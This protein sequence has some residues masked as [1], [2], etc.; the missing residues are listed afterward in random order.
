MMPGRRLSHVENRLA[1]F[2]DNLPAQFPRPFLRQIRIEGGP[3]L[4]GIRALAIPFPYPLTV[5]CGRNG[6]GKSTILGL[7][8]VSAKAPQGWSVFWGNTR[9][10]T[11]PNV[12]LEYSFNDFFHRRR[13][14]PSLD[15]LIL[16][17]VSFIQGNDVEIRETP[18]NRRWIRVNE[19]GRLPQRERK[20][21][22]EIDFIPMARILPAS[23]LGVVRAAFDTEDNAVIEPLNAASI[24]ALSFIMGR[25]YTAAETKF[26]RGLGLA[27]CH[28]GSDYS[29]FDMGSGENSVISLLSRLQMIP[30]G[31]LV[32][33]EEIELGL[34]AEA[35]VRLVEELLNICD[36]RR[37][38]IICTTHSEVVLDAVPRRARVLIRKNGD[39][40]EALVDV[41]TRFAVHEMTGQAQPELLAYTEDRLAAAIV[42]EAIPGAQWPRVKILDVGSNAT[43]ARQ[44]VAHL[45]MAPNIKSVAIFD[46]DCTEA[47]VLQWIRE[48]RAERDLQPDWLILPADGLAPEPW[49]IRE[50]A[51]ADYLSEFCRALDCTQAIGLGHIQ[52]MAAQRDHHDSGYTL[53]QRTGLSPDVARRL[54]VSSIARRHPALQPLRDK[55]SELLNT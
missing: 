23:D 42:Q 36:R 3:G 12:R 32:V 13:G 37:L 50:L 8:A 38:Q 47:E 25:Q 10:R 5:I 7:A 40:H 9:P 33:I 21:S 49:M 39:E 2:W 53:S 55:V 27:N 43:L 28:S 20:P 30:T 24:A 41:S 35:Q 26:K 15:G 14:A 18:R 54:I 11:N 19:A 44:A 6:V 4:R 17:W 45:R 1:R 34:H 16:T 22:R 31:G 51:T 48:E 29:G 46:G 52:A